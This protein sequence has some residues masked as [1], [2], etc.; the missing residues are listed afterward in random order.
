MA[1][2]TP[3]GDFVQ[4]Q[5]NNGAPATEQTEVWILFDDENLYISGKA[6]DS[7]PDRW[8]V[9]EMRRDIP[10][11]S[12]NE[13]VGFSL[14][15]FNDKRNGFLFEGN[16]IGGFLD[17]QIT[18]EGFPP[19]QNWNA[20][21][22]VQV[23]RFEGGWTFEFVVPFR[24]LRYRP[25]ASQVWGFNMRRVVRW[26]NEESHIVPVP[27][28]LGAKRGLI[29]V[30]LSAPLVGIEAPPGGKNLELRPYGISSL[31]TDRTRGSR[32]VE[33]GVR[34]RRARREVRPDAEPHGRFHGEHRLR[35]GGG[36]RATGEPHAV[37]PVLP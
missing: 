32:D 25:G 37:Q 9:N 20:V 22:D 7:Q 27:P 33:Q 1:E 16:A 12:N 31:T 26:K 24:S 28:S 10:N 5:P 11:V 17:A 34:R 15:T 13:S 35:P 14:D 29:Q 18:N 8:V 23:G 21:W 30:S 19:N 2:V 36:G 6:Y 4:Y 3:I